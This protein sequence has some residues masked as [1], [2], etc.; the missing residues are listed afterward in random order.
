MTY[1]P[2]TIH[3]ATLIGSAPWD[4]PAHILILAIERIEGEH[5]LTGIVA[6]DANP[7]ASSQSISLRG[8]LVGNIVR[9]TDSLAAS[10]RTAGD[11]YRVS[12]GDPVSTYDD[13]LPG[14]AT[15]VA[16]DL[17]DWWGPVGE[18]ACGEEAGLSLMRAAQ[19][20]QSIRELAEGIEESRDDLIR[21]MIAGGVSVSSIASKVGL[22][23]QRIYQIR[24]G[25]R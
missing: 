5:I 9:N 21:R 19:R 25:R 13:D 6:Q 23:R 11:S 7:A 22:D 8:E 10:I 4:V 1:Q 17:A 12:I 18:A 20:V 15:W 14:L 24:D 16:K 3:Q 2:G